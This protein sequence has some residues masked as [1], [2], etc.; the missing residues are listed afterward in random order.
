MEYREKITNS[1]L[2]KNFSDKEIE[3]LLTSPLVKIQDYPKDHIIFRQGESPQKLYLLIEGEVVIEN[4]SINGRRIVVATIDKTG[5]IFGEVFLFLGKSG[6]DHFAKTT[7]KSR[8][9]EI[10]KNIFTGTK[11]YGFM[12]KMCT[13]MLILLANKA[14]YLNTRLQV[15]SCIGIRQKISKLLLQ[16]YST[17]NEKPFSMNREDLAAY[18]AT[19]RPSLSR[20]LSKMNEEGIIKVEGKQIFIS[21]MD[22]L[23]DLI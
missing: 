7:V 10:S 5:G 14:Y 19:T 20:E 3:E 16:H 22:K 2:F 8:V 6:Y 17:N 15:T 1:P 21:D 23:M 9:L 11:D 18:I 4:N 12:N 13:N